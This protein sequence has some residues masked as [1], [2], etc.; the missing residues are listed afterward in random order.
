ML[1]ILFLRK[2]LPLAAAAPPPIKLERI[3]LF[4]CCWRQLVFHHPI[5]GGTWFFPPLSSTY[6]SI[7]ICWSF[8]LL[9]EFTS[10]RP[11]FYWDHQS[12]RSSVFGMWVCRF[13]VVYLTKGHAIDRF[14]GPEKDI[15]C[16]GETTS[17]IKSVG[18]SS[19][20]NRNQ[21]ELWSIV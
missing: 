19:Y 21:T 12:N 20:L 10:E 2:L 4:Y 6:S 5:H 14:V 16:D 7:T 8:W 15:V 3:L 1:R 13:C 11:S 17:E 9:G 18:R